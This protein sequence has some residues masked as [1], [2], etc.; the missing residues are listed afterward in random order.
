MTTTRRY[1]IWDPRDGNGFPRRDEDGNITS[2][3]LIGVLTEDNCYLTTYATGKRREG[4]VEYTPVSLD[5][6]EEN[7]HR[8]VIADFSLSGSKGTYEIYRVSDAK[9]TT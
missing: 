1:I 4:L 2:A 7:D 3:G 6:L 8:P 5:V 9:E